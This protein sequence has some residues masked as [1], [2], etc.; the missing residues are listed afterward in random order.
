MSVGVVAPPWVGINGG[1]EL[2]SYVANRKTV[3]T[4][5]CVF[6][7]AKSISAVWE[8]CIWP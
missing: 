1:A 3:W 6:R 8:R 2:A 5:Q 7:N 4:L